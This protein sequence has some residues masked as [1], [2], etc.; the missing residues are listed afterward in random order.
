[1][2]TTVLSDTLSG[3]II[4]NLWRDQLREAIA[5]GAITDPSASTR[6][7]K[8]PMVVTEFPDHTRHYPHI[9]VSEIAD[10]SGRPDIRADL[11]KHQYTVGL[12]I[13][14]KTST[15]MFHIRDQVRG[16][17]ESNTALFNT[18]NFH[19]AEIVSTTSMSLDPTEQVRSWRIAVRGTVYTAPASE[20]GD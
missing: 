18:M 1:M 4:V 13:H 2:G 10:V 14:A 3:S 11:W 12:E 15:H 17:I 19:D 5:A 8:S 16:W 7:R 20:E 9:V 6:P